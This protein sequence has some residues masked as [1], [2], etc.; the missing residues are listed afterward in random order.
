MLRAL[1]TIPIV[2]LASSAVGQEGSSAAPEQSAQVGAP[3]ATE[4]RSTPRPAI[5]VLQ[6]PYDLGSFYRSGGSAPEG[7]AGLTDDPAYSLAGFYRSQPGRLAPSR[8]GWSRFWTSGYGAER[9][10][11]LRPYRRSVGEN[12][13]LFLMVP[14]LAPVAPISGAFLGQ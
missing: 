14:F 2:V 4:E 9:P 12:G 5:R 7:W 3:A 10:L 1:L 13:D 11:P 6:N 8:Y